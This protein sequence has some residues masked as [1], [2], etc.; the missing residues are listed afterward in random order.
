[1]FAYRV[2]RV[3]GGA[4]TVGLDQSGW[5]MRTRRVWCDVLVAIPLL[6]SLLA[7]VGYFVTARELQG[8]LFT[9]GW[10]IL[11]VI[12][13]FSVA[14]RGVLVATRRTAWQ[15]AEERYARKREEATQKNAG[16]EGSEAL[17][18][19]NQAPEIDTVSVS[20]Q[21]QALLRAISGVV[22]AVL[23]WN[24]WKG[25]VPAL[26]VFNEVAL[27]SHANTAGGVDKVTVVTLGSLLLSLALFA[28]TVI[29]ARNLPGFLEVT[30][31]QRL[32]IDSGTRYAIGTI[33]RYLIIGVGLVAAF[34]HIGADWSQLQ[35]IVAALGVGLGFGLQEIVANFVSGLII[36]FE[37]PVRVGDLISIGPTTGTVSRIRIRAIT[38]TDFDNFEVMVPNK[39]FITETVRNWSLTSQVTRVVIDVG[40]AYGSDVQQIQRIMLEVAARNPHVLAKP[41]PSAFFLSFGDSALQFQLRVY[42]GTI[43]ERL[44]TQHALLVALDAAF[45]QAAIA[46]P[47]PQRDVHVRYPDGVPGNRAESRADE[48]AG[49]RV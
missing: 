27:W 38:I 34:D 2:F 20:Q 37:R 31:L 6:L 48:D 36:L 26:N 44:S 32:R 4:L 19:Q 41:A 35:W 49:D 11:A 28:L 14:M 40:V 10:I 23:L 17:N 46:I 42:V 13:V 39:S 25:L 43:D 16:G 47:F 3:R 29:A 8:R 33:G 18:L 30:V 15:Q 7:G 9:S 12:I 21:T 5:A 45:K 1:M 22:L 24:V